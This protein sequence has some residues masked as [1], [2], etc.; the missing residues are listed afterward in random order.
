VQIEF[1]CSPRTSGIRAIG[2]SSSVILIY[3]DKNA[4]RCLIKMERVSELTGAIGGCES[5]KSDQA[6]LRHAIY[7][8]PRERIVVANFISANVNT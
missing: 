3:P 2:I 7:S 1:A 8:V 5:Y 6:N 4:N